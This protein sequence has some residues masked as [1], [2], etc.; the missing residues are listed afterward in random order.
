M[1][2]HF[3]KAVNPYFQ[4]LWDGNKTFEIRLDD[5]GYAGYAVGDVL[6]LQEY[7]L[8][9]GIKS[10]REIYADVPYILRG[11]PYLPQGYVCMSLKNIKRHEWNKEVEGQ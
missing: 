7:D 3:L 5:R 8:I 2:T 9:A 10:G 1:Q 11:E 6:V 4:D